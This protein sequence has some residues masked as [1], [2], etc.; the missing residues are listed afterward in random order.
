[1][2]LDATARGNWGCPPD[3]YPAAL[4]LVL[5]GKVAIQPFI[6]RHRLQDAPVVFDTIAGHA[7]E[8]P[9]R[10]GPGREAHA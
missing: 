3:Q 4:A 8:A 6:E 9:C 1:M 5:E 10:A 2:A 7:D